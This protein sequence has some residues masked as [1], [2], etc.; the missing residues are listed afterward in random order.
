[1]VE[2]K[3][4]HGRLSLL[5]LQHC[6]PEAEEANK[7]LGPISRPSSFSSDVLVAAINLTMFWL[8]LLIESFSWNSVIVL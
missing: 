5:W 7:N 6:F 4:G 2:S 3:L 1:M 8:L